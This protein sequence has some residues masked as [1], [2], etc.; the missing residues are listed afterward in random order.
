MSIRITFCFTLLF[1]IYTTTK[2]QDLAFPSAEGFGK[3]A[4]GGRGG[5]VI[6]VTNLKDSGPG[7][8]REALRE[9]FPRIV[10]F[11]VS[12][13]I[14]L[15]S[16]LDVNY[17]HLTIAGQSAPGDGITLKNF[18][19]KIK[20][21][22][23][24]VRYIRV[25]MGDEKGEQDD[26][27]SIIKQKNIII[28]HC[29]FS[30]ATDE[31]ASFYDNEN[32]TL[33]WCIISE[34]LN[35]SV[36]K[37]G[38]HGYGGIWGGKNATFHHNLLAHH[39]SRNPRFNGSRYHKQPELEVVDFRNNVI[40][41][42]QDN[43]SY[44]GERG[45]HNIVN[46]YYKPGPSTQSKKDKILNPYEPL[47][48]FYLY[49][50]ILEGNQNV[51]EDNWEGVTIKSGNY[52]SARLKDPIEVAPILMYTADEAFDVVLSKAGSSLTRDA[53]DIRVIEETKNGTATFKNGIIDSQSEVG[54]WP[55][56]KTAKYPKDTDGDGMP[57]K[58]E[59]KHQLNPKA[60]DSAL[61]G[62]STSYTNVEFY[63]NSLIS[64]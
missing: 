51:N 61:F 18:P 11:S 30:W 1:L 58:W 29:S 38:E 60:D 10:V 14:E 50:N 31:C 12:G 27:I 25:R 36:H 4:S 42:W 53:V 32:F 22:N 24:I 49:G 17:G 16:D 41:N 34:S 43:N 54:G 55:I 48:M 5:K 64:E 59:K 15:L 8:L 21:E 19:L 26:A 52:D 44:G 46:N 40:Y 45:N 23:V 39:K 63:L 47:G 57:D 2:C 62:L 7:S 3:Y 13:T 9:K 6:T 37:K 28:D 20:D 56:L 35:A 33:Q